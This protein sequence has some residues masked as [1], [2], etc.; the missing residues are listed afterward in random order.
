MN[1]SNSNLNFSKVSLVFH[2]SLKGGSSQIYRCLEQVGGEPVIRYTLNRMCTGIYGLGRRVVIVHEADSPVRHVLEG[3]ETA[4]H[5]SPA[6]GLVSALDEWCSLGDCTDTIMVMP[7]NAIFPD[8]PMAVQMLEVHCRSNADCTIAPEYP[9]GYTPI[10]LQAACIPKLSALY[11]SGGPLEGKMDSYHSLR[12]VLMSVQPSTSTSSIEILHFRHPSDAAFQVWELPSSV[13]VVDKHTRQAADIVMRNRSSDDTLDSTDARNFRQVLDDLLDERPSIVPMAR[14]GSRSAVNVLFWSFTTP[15]FS[16]TGADKC[17]L[18]LITGLDRSRF[19]PA[20]GAD[21]KSLI[22]EQARAMGIPVEIADHNTF[23]L[24]RSNLRYWDEVFRAYDIDLVHVDCYPNPPLMVTAFQRGIPILGHTRLVIKEILPSICSCAEVIVAPSEYIADSLRQVRWNPRK[25][26]K[27]YEGVDLSEFDPSQI[28]RLQARQAFNIPDGAFVILMVARL[29]PSK[30]HDV[31]IH[32]LNHLRNAHPEA[33]L[34]FVGDIYNAQY[35]AY[36]RSLISEL[37][38]QD[39][40]RLL[41][42]QRDIRPLYKISDALIVCNGQE[43]LGH[44]VLEAM[45][46]GVPTIV[47]RA[48]G[49][50]EIVRDGIEGFHY[51]TFDAQDLSLKLAYLRAP[52]LHRSLSSAARSRSRDFDLLTHINAMSRL[53]ESMLSAYRRNH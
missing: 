45:A 10:I 50:K 38:L 15:E 2:V 41:S 40:V 24:T 7:E 47:P 35:F 18:S 51:E 28:D 20:L 3:S 32:A 36:V 53:Y 39:Q 25:I 26:V 22:A 37:G 19:Q 17:L 27:V 52:E 11:K 6:G 34:L 49:P 21:A 8:C 5:V 1:I 46:M 30:R 9:V 4:F 48:G 44:N 12:T 13:L 33:I 29:D 14:S 43:G 23:E 31:A 16:F 42:F